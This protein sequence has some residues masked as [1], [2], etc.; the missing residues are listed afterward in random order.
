MNKKEIL[1][2]LEKAVDKNGDIPMRLVR[3]AFDKLPEECDDTVS[4]DD[5]RKAIRDF[6]D[7]ECIASEEFEHKYLSRIPK[8]LPQQKVGHWVGIDDE[9]YDVYECD[10]CGTTYDTCDSTWDVPY[11]CPNC[12]AKMNE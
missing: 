10:V 12:G 2:I 8:K 4:R 5:V 11:F 6:Y 3:Q 9:P 1:K 7:G